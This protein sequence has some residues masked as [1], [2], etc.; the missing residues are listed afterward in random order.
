MLFAI[1]LY[2]NFQ[3]I[4]SQKSLPFEDYHT[5]DGNDH[6]HQLSHIKRLS[7]RLKKPEQFHNIC[8]QQLRDHNKHGRSGRSYLAHAYYHSACD[9]HT[10]RTSEQK[11]ERP[12][13]HQFE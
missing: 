13:L 9:K 6:S 1:S 3:G 10:D 5:N 11:I 8:S 4:A 2:A 12:D 7:F